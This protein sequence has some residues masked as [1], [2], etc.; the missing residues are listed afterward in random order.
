MKRAFIFGL[1][2][3][4]LAVSLANAQINTGEIIGTVK[5]A[6]GSPVPGVTVSLTGNVTG[7]DERH[8][9]DPG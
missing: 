2:A 7:S 3:C 1:L 5:L 8:H 9:L 4:A 6:D